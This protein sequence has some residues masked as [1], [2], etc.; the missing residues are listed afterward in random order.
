MLRRRMM[1][2]KAQEVEEMKEWQLIYDTKETAEEI[3]SISDINVKGFNELMVIARVV[4]TTTN[5]SA[6]NGQLSLMSSD[7]NKCQV[8]LGSN[9][10][11]PNGNPRLCI[12]LVKRFSD[13]IYVDTATS[14]NANDVFNNKWAADNLTSMQNSIVKYEGEID[15]IRITNANES[16]AYKFGIGSRFAIYGR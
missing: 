12:A 7:G 14:W 16:G 13:F 1:M 11:Y 4:A 6:R 8:V 9:L 2:A 10:L 3:T 5:P 15:K